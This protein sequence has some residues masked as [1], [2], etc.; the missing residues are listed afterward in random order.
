[1]TLTKNQKNILLISAVVLVVLAALGY[2]YWR[3][4]QRKKSMVS[5]TEGEELLS[6][7]SRIVRL[8]SDYQRNDESQTEASVDAS[9]RA[10]CPASTPFPAGWTQQNSPLN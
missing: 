3:T 1:M 10:E 8:V 4:V 2:W 5:L 9:L 6:E 7:P